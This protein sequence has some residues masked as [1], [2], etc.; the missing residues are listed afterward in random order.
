MEKLARTCSKAQNGKARVD[1]LASNVEV[2]RYSHLLRSA[3]REDLHQTDC[4]MSEKN[5]HQLLL[6][7]ETQ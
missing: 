4:K 7:D 6:K 2:Y 3:A 5:P 1:S